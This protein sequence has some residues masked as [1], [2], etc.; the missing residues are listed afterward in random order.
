MRLSSGGYGVGPIVSVRGH[1]N[2]EKNPLAVI[3]NY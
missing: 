2:D 1:K 3:L